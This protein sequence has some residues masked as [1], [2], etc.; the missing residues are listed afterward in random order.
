M[1][2]DVWR[3]DALPI[4]ST[5]RTRTL[6]WRRLRPDWLRELAKRWA[7]HKLRL[8][9]SPVHVN[10][11]RLAALRLAEFTE[12][13]GWPLDSPACLTRELF[14]AFQDHVWLIPHGQLYKGQIAFGVKQL[15][16]ESHDLGWIRLR[17][18]R[19]FLPGELPARGGGL[20][21]ALPATVV[22]RLNDSD[23][24][25]LL[26]V[27]ERAMVLV[28]MDGGLRAT[29]TAR[30]RFDV[31]MVGSDGAPYLRY[32]NHKRRREAVVPVS[33][34]AV[35]AIAAQQGWVREHFPGCEWLFPRLLAN[36][37]GKEPMGYGAVYVRE[38]ADARRRTIRRS[39]MVD[40]FADLLGGATDGA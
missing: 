26:T 31:V 37:R 17:N 14:D 40:E 18:P 27:A 7:R 20:P 24:L 25:G 6:D 19:V 9:I 4:E 34:R 11:V 30:L 33:D 13:A 16:E 3:T 1:A 15:F 32:W 29:D 23:A 35:D 21:R 28:L 8:G 36:G 39:R 2:H 22:K 12:H 5:T 38:L 10:G